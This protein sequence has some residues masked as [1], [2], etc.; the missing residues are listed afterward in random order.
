[1]LW[2]GEEELKGKIGASRCDAA[3]QEVKKE[4]HGELKVKLV[5]VLLMS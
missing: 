2:R 4:V 1:L 5:Y 3:S